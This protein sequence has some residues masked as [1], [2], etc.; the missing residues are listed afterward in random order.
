MSGAVK[1]YSVK[2]IFYSLQGEGLNTGRA[3]VFIRFAGCNLSCPFCDTDWKNGKPMSAGEIVAEAQSL[4]KRQLPS[5]VVLTGGEP[6]LQVDAHLVDL[7][8]T[9]F[10][11]V[12]IE[13]NGTRP[14]PRGVDFI[15]LS[16][17]E[18]FC[19]GGPE[20]MI[21]KAD[22]VKVVFDANH[23]PEFWFAHTMAKEYFLQPCDTGNEAQNRYINEKCVK[24]IKEH[25]WWRLSLQTQKILSIR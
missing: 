24:Y 19:S 12:A 8:H 2:E 9:K 22:E 7:L 6:T 20:V 21:G 13:T 25:P 17:K 14:I 1:A 18:D 4:A 3:A 10:A 5:L 15:T 16:P 11:E 23:N